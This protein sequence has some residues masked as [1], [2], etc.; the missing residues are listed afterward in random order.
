M[1]S[2][3]DVAVLIRLNSHVQALHARI[4][5]SF[6]KAITDADELEA[7]FETVLA[8]PNNRVILAED[9]AAALGY[10]WFQE[11]LVPETPFT[12][13]RQRTYIY[14]IAVD[15]AARRRGIGSALL[16]H[17]EELAHD[18]GIDT[19]ALDTWASNSTAQAFFSARGY[20]TLTIGCE[21]Q[22]GIFQKQDE[23]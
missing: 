9:D 1:A 14:Q 22:I 13:P 3:N 8:N 17:V 20:S 6:F 18:A 21:K 15:E 11:Q 5:P 10:I 19:L 2:I 7:Y 16:A 23:G 12:W 4:E